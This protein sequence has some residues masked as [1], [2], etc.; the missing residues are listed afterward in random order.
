[1]L[2][3]IFLGQT[4]NF[5]NG[6]PAEAFDVVGEYRNTFYQSI[7]MKTPESVENYWASMIFTGK[8]K[9]PRQIQPNEAKQLVATY[10]RAISYIDRSQ[11]DTSVKVINV[12][13]GQ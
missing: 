1:E 11:V 9:P 13:N 12:T 5:P 2:R 3:R 6:D 10:P 4:G 8:A 7:L